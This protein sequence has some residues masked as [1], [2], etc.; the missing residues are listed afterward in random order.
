MSVLF[1]WVMAFGC[2]GKCGTCRTYLIWYP[3]K[4][5]VCHQNK[6]IAVFSLPNRALTDLDVLAEI[7]NP[8]K[9][10]TKLSAVSG[11]DISSHSKN[12]SSRYISTSVVVRRHGIPS[13]GTALRI[14][15]R[16]RLNHAKTGPSHSI[17]SV[18]GLGRRWRPL[19]FPICTADL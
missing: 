9:N 8:K 15:L 5:Y 11:L 13:I 18:L 2:G 6:N 7:A 16:R 3:G 14:P 17:M 1:C 12:R 4:E 10:K 19:C